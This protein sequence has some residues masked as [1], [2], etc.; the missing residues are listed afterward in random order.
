MQFKANPGIFDDSNLQEPT[1]GWWDWVF[2]SNQPTNK[3][4]SEGI[5]DSTVC[6]VV[7]ACTVC[8][9]A[10]FDNNFYKCS[11]LRDGFD[12]MSTSN[13]LSPQNS[14]TLCYLW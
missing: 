9:V 1:S 4:L 11:C 14:T 10:C 13:I 12:N 3:E 6:S 7:T 8:S 5:L 2:G